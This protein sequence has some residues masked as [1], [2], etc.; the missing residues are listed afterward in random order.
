MNVRNARDAAELLAPLL[1]DAE[2]EVL[3]VAHLD[4]DRRLL[5]LERL[6]GGADAVTLPVREIVRSALR[7]GAT[8]IVIAHSHPSGNPRPSEADLLATRRLAAAAGA[9][10]IR[11]DDHLIFANGACRSLR[12]AG[13]L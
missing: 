6:A 8:G 13:L 10:G 1:E 11:V 2:R 4:A 3:A 5:H 7:N 9:A 12:G